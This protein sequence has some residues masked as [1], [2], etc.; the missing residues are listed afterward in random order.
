MEKITWMKLPSWR[1]SVRKASFAVGLRI[2]WLLCTDYVCQGKHTGK[3]GHVCNWH[4]YL[5]G[6]NDLLTSVACED[7]MV[8]KPSDIIHRLKGHS[9]GSARE[10]GLVRK[11]TPAAVGAV[12]P[13]VVKLP[14]PLAIRCSLPTSSLFWFCSR[15]KISEG[16]VL[17]AIMRV[18]HDCRS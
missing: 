7:G 16:V 6:L 10:P 13:V 14:K 1:K 17:K 8:A 9:N 2:A 11:H 18:D 4:P 5:S 3:K 12:R 15:N